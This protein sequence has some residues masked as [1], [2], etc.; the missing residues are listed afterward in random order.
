MR[1]SRRRVLGHRGPARRRWPSRCRHGR[2][3][4]PA[5]APPPPRWALAGP[6]RQRADHM[7]ARS[8]STLSTGR[9]PRRRPRP[10]PLRR[11][12]PRR[13]GTR[14]GP[15]VAGARR[16][17]SARWPRCVGTRRPQVSPSSTVARASRL[18]P[19]AQL[20][21][22][23]QARD[24]FHQR[25]PAAGQ[26]AARRGQR[27]SARWFSWSWARS[28]RGSGCHVLGGSLSGWLRAWRPS[29][30]AHVQRI[31]PALRRPSVHGPVMRTAAPT[32]FAARR[33]R[34]Q[35]PGGCPPQQQAAPAGMPAA[36]SA[37]DEV[38]DVPG[39]KRR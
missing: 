28:R 20:L 21:A 6:A 34:R 18:Q 7:P 29:C 35:R 30:I 33:S 23:G 11:A 14:A 36:A 22:R 39:P 13:C 2:R 8:A 3:A 38:L 24:G 17:R 12:A 31:R 25:V 27:V 9:A 16:G 1:C 15:L 19:L 10:W 26:R 4:A 37:F 32:R 5:A